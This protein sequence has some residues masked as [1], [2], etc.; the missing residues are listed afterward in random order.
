VRIAPTQRTALLL[1]A[2]QV[3]A[4]P[5]TRSAPIATVRAERPL[6]GRS[7][8]LPVLAARTDAGGRRWLRVRLPGRVLGQAGPP[9]TGWMRAAGTVRLSSAWHVLIRVPSREVIVFHRG[10]RARTFSAVVGAAA[11]P[12]P[13]GEYFVEEPVRLGTGEPGAPFAFALSARSNVLQEFEGGPGQ[14]ALH[15]RRHLGGQLGTAVSHGCIR[16][17]DRAL[18]WLSDRIGRGVPVTIS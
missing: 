18:A 5:S 14:V 13:R 8:I 16:V 7:T 9:R 6:T 11:T 15:G 1:A 3:R 10:R 12:T 4:L 2:H 17:T